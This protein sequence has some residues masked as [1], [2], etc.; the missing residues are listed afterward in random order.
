MTRMSS[1]PMAEKCGQAARLS[2][3]HGAGRPAAM[4]KAFHAKCAGAPEAFRLIGALSHAERDEIAEWKAPADALVNGWCVLDYAS[5]AKELE[6]GL[7]HFGMYTDTEE[8]A[9]TW[10]H[11]DFAWVRELDGLRVAFV[12]DIKKSVWT[13]PEGP[14]SLQLQAYGMAFAQKTECQAYCTGIWAAKEGKWLWSTDIVL[15]D[16]PV[17]Q[18]IWQRIAHAAGNTGEAST[19][20]HCDS[21]FARLH[22]PEYLLPGTVNESMAKATQLADPSTI[23]SLALTNA[24]ALRLLD[25]CDRASTL[26]ERVEKNLREAVRR[27]KLVIEDGGKVWSPVEM[28]GRES[29]DKDKLRAVGCEPGDFVKKGD[30]YFQMRWKKART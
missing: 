24:E 1:L 22:C 23:D 4:S 28:P 12:G 11:L 9:L 16:G 15:L 13:T 19:G 29:L 21:C 10:G 30:P 8:G 6:V 5:A 27:G 25:W 14:D 2:A 26:A 18:D 7:D 20:R 3:Q 17:G